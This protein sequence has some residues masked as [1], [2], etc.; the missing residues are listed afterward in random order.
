MT[1]SLPEGT[2]RRRRGRTAYR[3]EVAET[4]AE[5]REAQ[6]LRYEVFNQEMGEGL[7]SSQAEGV[8]RDEFDPQFRHLLVRHGESGKLV[9]TY[10]LQSSAMAAAGLGF[11][12]EREF[13]LSTLPSAMRGQA[14]EVGRACIDAAHRNSRVL[15]LLWRGIGE[16]L[17][18]TGTRHVFGCC[19]LSSQHPADG[20]G[21]LETLRK[22]GA[23]ADPLRVRPHPAFELPSSSESP[24]IEIPRLFHLYLGIGTRVVSQPAIDREFGTID[25]LVALDTAD[26][27]ERHRQLFLASPASE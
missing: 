20:W 19:S 24:A 26:L 3:L 5:L 7:A 16:Q 25:Y 4:E 13:D 11:Y 23:V 27:D 21:L 18:R 8:D 6:R 12:A 1:A 9:G 22:S 15:F 17:R 2:V 14:L 10:R